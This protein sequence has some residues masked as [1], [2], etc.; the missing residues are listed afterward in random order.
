MDYIFD[1]IQKATQA[2][3]SKGSTTTMHAERE[4]FDYPNDEIARILE[5]FYHVRENRDEETLQSLEECRRRAVE[6]FTQLQKHKY[7]ECL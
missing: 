7:F 2:L 6:A 3:S 1:T 4:L 5:E